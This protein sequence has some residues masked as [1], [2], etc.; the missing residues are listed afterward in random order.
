M[1]SPSEL[2]I[3]STDRRLDSDAIARIEDTLKTAPA[4]SLIEIDLSQA[5]VANTAGFAALVV[6]RRRLLDS[7]RDLRIS[8]LHYKTYALYRMLKLADALPL[9]K[10]TDRHGITTCE[11][12]LQ[13][14][15]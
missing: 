15:N 6:M 1:I 8:G 9:L 12:A 5:Q 14:S 11:T 3:Q 10:F 7:G 4:A 2:T 13:S